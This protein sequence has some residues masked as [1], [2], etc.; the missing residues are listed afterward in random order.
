MM[1]HTDVRIDDP[2][3]DEETGGLDH[4]SNVPRRVADLPPLPTPNKP[5]MRS[6]SSTGITVV[7][8][9]CHS[10]TPATD[11]SS[12]SLPHCPDRPT[13]STSVH[14]P[15]GKVLIGICVGIPNGVL[16]GQGWTWPADN[17]P[18]D[19]VAVGM[20]MLYVEAIIALVCLAGIVFGDPGVIKRSQERCFPIPEPVLHR[21]RSGQSLVGMDNFYEGSNV[22]CVRC[23]LWRSLPRKGFRDAEVHHCSI[24]QRCVRDFDHQC[25]PPRLLCTSLPQSWITSLRTG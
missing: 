16:H 21:L 6:E 17:E 20:L 15:C 8:V 19:G 25:A 7:L 24:C 2:M 22:Y 10:S 18:W 12:Y 1:L 4:D 14:P 5:V 11:L 23:C 9:S 3:E 13:A